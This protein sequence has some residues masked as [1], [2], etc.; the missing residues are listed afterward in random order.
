MSSAA[1][2]RAHDAF[3]RNF[4]ER[5]EGVAFAPGRVNLIGDHV[6]YNDGLVMPMPLELGTAV[7]W[8]SGEGQLIRAAAGDFGDAT[9]TLG[10][11]AETAHDCGWQTYLRGMVAVLDAHAKDGRSLDLAISGDLPRGAGL[12]SSASYCIALGRAF[13]AAGMMAGPLTQIDLAKAAQ[14]TEHDYAKVACGIMDQMASACGM[15]SH[16]MLLDCRTLGWRNLALPADWTVI[17]VPSG[18][19]R[20]LVDGEYNLRRSQCDEAARLLGVATLRD[21][22]PADFDWAAL[23]AVERNRARHVIEEIAR[24]G[25][26]TEYVAQADLAGFG[27]C[28]N[29]SH[30]SLRDLFEVSHPDVDRLVDILQRA[31]GADG[32]ARMTGGGFG[33]AVVAI[34]AS[35]EVDRIRSIVAQEYSPAAA[36]NTLIAGND[37]ATS[38][39]GQEQFGRSNCQ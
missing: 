30:R 27:D 25:E 24:V 37:G 18:A 22:S 28:L 17:I 36:E 34:A 11:G 3:I 21:V 26:A 20:G 32:G 31:I 39:S 4:G 35:S 7:A 33:G 16:A 23:P 1:K 5:P 9:C 10:P 38:Q 19:T 14:R 6:D 2:Q 8:R 12:S 15:P 29:Q 13:I